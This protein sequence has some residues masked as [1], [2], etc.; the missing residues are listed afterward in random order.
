MDA[1]SGTNLLLGP[2]IYV[3][4]QSTKAQEEMVTKLLNS[5][6][7]KIESFNT[8]VSRLADQ[9]IGANLGIRG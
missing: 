7:S 8:T 3:I 6:Q 4:K 1:L 2:E 5:L 9:G